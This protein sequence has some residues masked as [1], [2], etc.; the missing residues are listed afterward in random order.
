MSDAEIYLLC[1]RNMT[2]LVTPEN[3][4]TPAP[5]C[6]GWTV[7]DVLAHQTGALQDFVSGATEGAPSPAWTATHIERFRDADVTEIADVWTATV[8]ALGNKGDALLSRLVPDITV[9]EFDIRGALGNTDGRDRHPGF[10]PTFRFITGILDR[11]YREEG[12]PPLEFN[13]DDQIVVLGD[14]EPVGSVTTSM[15]E[16]S[17]V[18]SGR[19][20]PAQIAALAWSTD[21]GPWLDHLSPLGKRDTDLI[22]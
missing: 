2:D 8:N 10:L 14:G 11:M 9:H 19:R 13:A 22:E 3:Q 21:P 12:L 5:A 15:F 7:H 16:A 1:K 18:L 4:H 6:P 17:R 20:S